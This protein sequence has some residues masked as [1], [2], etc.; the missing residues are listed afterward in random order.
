MTFTN[1]R[2]DIAE[3]RRQFPPTATQ[4]EAETAIPQ[5]GRLFQPVGKIFVDGSGHKFNVLKYS[6]GRSA[7]FYVAEPLHR[8]YQLCGS[9]ASG[10]QVWTFSG[11]SVDDF[12]RLIDIKPFNEWIK[13]GL[14]GPTYTPDEL[15]AAADDYEDELNSR[16]DT[17]LEL[18]CQQHINDP[19]LPESAELKFLRKYK[20]LPQRYFSLQPVSKEERKS[21][22]ERGYTLEATPDAFTHMTLIGDGAA[23]Y[24]EDYKAKH[25]KPPINMFVYGKELSNADLIAAASAV[26]P[27]DPN[28]EPELELTELVARPIFPTWIM[29]GTSLYNGLI[30]PAIDKSS[31]YAEMI[32]VP[33]VQLLLNVISGR[34]RLEFRN[35]ILNIFLGVVAP[36]GKFFKSSCCELCHLYFNLMGLCADYTP[37]TSNADGKVQ[38][39]SAGSPEGIGLGMT[40]I[41][42]K[43]AILY[44]DELTKFTSK[45]GIENSS[46]ASELTTIYESGRFG[47]EIKSKKQSFAFAAGSY[48]FGWCWCTTDGNFIKNW[49][50]LSGMTSGL[51][52]RMFFLITP[53]TPRP[54]TML[55][56]PELLP[57]AIETKKL[58]DKAITQG[59][60]AYE[61]R[62]AVEKMAVGL[63]PRSIGLLEKFALYFAVDLGRDVIDVDCVKR[64]KALVVYRNQ[65]TKFLNPIEAEGPLA[66]LQVEMIRMLQNSE[67]KMRWREF[68]HKLHS[69][70]YGTELWGRAIKGLIENGT[71]D[72]KLKARPR[73]VYLLKQEGLV[74]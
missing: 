16:F 22:I 70:R 23:Q 33:G 18:Y 1:K 15:A 32:F 55:R 13:A 8:P 38:I 39:F 25:G 47:N 69:E 17:E 44:Y 53:A 2:E 35:L 61:N 48:C 66:R 21:L 60:Y 11:T 50:K 6:D 34:V 10:K 73:M 62:A 71:I 72:V 63:D 29:A 37:E 19:H 65:A 20:R 64:A 74:T 3:L 9:D 56:D 40:R 42:G 57:G 43:N 49:A 67:A 36:P 12:P 30:K 58:I 45:A 31:K 24:V 14:P 28:A 68:T 51:D 27:V 26:V 7:D 4:M 5:P 52:D 46:F 59:V 54:T 41:N